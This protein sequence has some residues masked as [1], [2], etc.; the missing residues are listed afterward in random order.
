MAGS[1]FPGAEGDQ[2]VWLNNFIAKLATHLATL[3]LVAG[4]LTAITNDVNAFVYMVGWSATY[5][6]RTQDVNDYKAQLLRGP[7]PIG[8]FP[9]GLTATVP[10]TA[11]AAN[12]L[13]RVTALVNRIKAAPGYNSAI[14]EDLGIESPVAP[15]VDLETAKPTFNALAM[16]DS[17]VRL[18]WTKG[19]FTGVRIEGRRN[20]EVAWTFLAVDTSSPYLD[21]REP[22]TGGIPESRSYRMRYLLGDDTVGLF[23]DVIEV[24]T[25]P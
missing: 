2:V 25:L 13:G 4:D 17:E 15:E 7:G 5:K 19:E 24:S 12:V 14:G 21:A 6:T 23:S 3:G 22:L 9:A 8:A 16:P 10:P 18:N 1:Y 20:A 11:V